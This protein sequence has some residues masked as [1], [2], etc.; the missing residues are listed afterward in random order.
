M[1]LYKARLDGHVHFVFDTAMTNA[2]RSMTVYM[3]GSMGDRAFTLKK[4]TGEYVVSIKRKD[5]EIKCIELPPK[6]WAFA[7]I[8]LLFSTIINYLFIYFFILCLSLRFLVQYLY[9]LS[10]HYLTTHFP[11]YRWAAFRQAI[12][13]VNTG[14]KAL[15]DG[16]EGVK[17]QHHI[18]GAN[19]ISVTSGFCCADLSKFYR[20]YNAKDDGEIKP[21]RKGVAL[22][23]EEWTRVL[24]ST[25]STW[26]ILPWAMLNHVVMETIIWTRLAGYNAWSATHSSTTR[27]SRLLE[28]QHRST[29]LRLS[30]AYIT[31]SMENFWHISIPFL[32]L[33]NICIHSCVQPVVVV[34]H[35]TS[36][37]PMTATTSTNTNNSDDNC[38]SVD[39]NPKIH[40][41]QYQNVN[42]FVLRKYDTSIKTCRG[43]NIAFTTAMQKFVISHKELYMYGWVKGSK[44]L[45][46]AEHNF[47]YHCDATRIK[48]R[49]T[50][51]NPRDSMTDIQ[52]SESDVELLRLCR[53]FLTFNV[54]SFGISG[55]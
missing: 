11:C 53:I 14:V 12:G 21:A 45:L 19:Y 5:D 40:R 1:V 49:H 54:T 25:P 9:L 13:D 50:Y 10:S 38:Q 3:L 4:C 52:P 35:P 43:C 44:R 32:A 51:F 47:F 55:K 26:L 8:T 7:L 15:A 29:H 6:R 48:L 41:K 22:R 18:G 27:P 33:T 20:P 31:I 36:R 16:V 37:L 34:T 2:A 39:Y 30:Y 46:K 23:R 17:I 24:M 42:P 28:V